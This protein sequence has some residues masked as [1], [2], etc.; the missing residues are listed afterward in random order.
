MGA[1]QL[2]IDA[3]SAQCRPPL[4]TS[5]LVGDSTSFAWD[6]RRP[7]LSSIDVLCPGSSI[8]RYS[9][10]ARSLSTRQVSS[11][12]ADAGPPPLTSPAA[13]HP[14]PRCRTSLQ[15]CRTAISGVGSSHR[16]GKVTVI[17]GPS[18]WGRCKLPLQ[19]ISSSP[20]IQLPPIRW[21]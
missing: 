7:P 4:S 15:P 6:L 19:S 14:L 16:G 2:R 5:E 13:R 9:P 8:V 21:Y 20:S 1:Q 10:H 18:Y 17:V 12:S 3:A 11:S